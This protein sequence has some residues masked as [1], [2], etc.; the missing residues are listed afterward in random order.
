MYNKVKKALNDM[1][2]DFKEYERVEFS[3]GVVI[4]KGFNVEKSLDKKVYIEIAG[5][6]EIEVWGETGNHLFTIHKKETFLMMF[7]L[8]WILNN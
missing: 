3:N 2:Y 6:G 8:G 4:G 1:A 7:E 5:N